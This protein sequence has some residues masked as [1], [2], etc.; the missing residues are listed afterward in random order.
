M[1]A[2]MQQKFNLKRFEVHQTIRKRQPQTTMKNCG[3]HENWLAMGQG[4]HPAP[5]AHPL[6]VAQ[7]GGPGGPCRAAGPMA[8]HSPAP[9]PQWVGLLPATAQPANKLGHQQGGACSCK[10][11]GKWVCGGLLLFQCCFMVGGG[12]HVAM[13]V[14]QFVC[15]CQVVMQL[16]SPKAQSAYTYPDAMSSTAS[17]WL[18]PL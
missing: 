2:P 18:V 7:K 1:R 3:N 10:L 14:R 9:G 11:G 17:K 8:P 16:H 15:S 4:C 13:Q 5:A 12:V 6:P